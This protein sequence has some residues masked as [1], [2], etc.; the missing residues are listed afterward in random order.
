METLLN[1]TSLLHHRLIDIAVVVLQVRTP[2]IINATTNVIRCG[3]FVRPIRFAGIVDVAVTGND[4]PRTKGKP[5]FYLDVRSDDTERYPT[6]GA[7]V[8]LRDNLLAFVLRHFR[9]IGTIEKF[10]L[11]NIKIPLMR[12]RSL[13]IRGFAQPFSKL[14]NL[15]ILLIYFL[16][17]TFFYHFKRVSNVSM[18]VT[19]I[20]ENP[21][22]RSIL[23]IRYHECR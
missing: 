23:F 20:V 14:S 13:S 4:K 8:S 2:E 21:T 17:S 9:C 12:S 3:C 6:F 11:Y 15:S 7:C 18:V 19:Q 5:S 10:A 1:P 16:L 22:N